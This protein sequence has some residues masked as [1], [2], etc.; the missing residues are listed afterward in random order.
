[1]NEKIENLLN[2]IKQN[3]DLPIAL[4]VDKNLLVNEDYDR[5]LGSIGLSRVDFYCFDDDEILFKSNTD[6][7]DYEYKLNWVECIVVNIDMP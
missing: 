7:E 2:L 3:P 1:M 6:E 4:M 5:Y